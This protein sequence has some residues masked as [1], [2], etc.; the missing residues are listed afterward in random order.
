L[1]SDLDIY[2]SYLG[3]KLLELLVFLE[4]RGKF[5]VA[6]VSGFLQSSLDVL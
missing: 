1:T 6:A 3:Q 4:P 2:G 5:F